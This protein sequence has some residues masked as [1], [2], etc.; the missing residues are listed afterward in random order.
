MKED[1]AWRLFKG[2]ERRIPGLSK[3]IVFWDL[4]TPL[5]NDH[6]LNV[7]RGNI[8]GISKTPKQVGPFAF[9]VKSE[10]EGLYMVGASTTS[11]GVSGVTRSGLECAKSILGVST[12]ELLS[13]N[14]PEIEIYP[15]EDISQWPEQLQK[16]IERNSEE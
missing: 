13:Q 15:S 3:H 11:H 7:T 2:L 10:L 5:T 4:G 6:Y 16:K 1:L 9:P 12:D 8:Y 14:G